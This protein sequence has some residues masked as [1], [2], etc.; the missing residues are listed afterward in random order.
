MTKNE[1]I[2]L[3]GITARIETVI[4]D[5]NRIAEQTD[6]ED[7]INAILKQLSALYSIIGD[8]LKGGVSA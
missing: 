3:I 6:D 2:Y 8:I 4:G 1:R 7:I 5:L